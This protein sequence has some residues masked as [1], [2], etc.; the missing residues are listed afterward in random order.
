VARRLAAI[1]PPDISAAVEAEVRNRMAQIV[2]SD[3]TAAIEAA[4]AQRIA[5]IPPPDNSAAIEAEVQRRLSAV[6]AG[7]NIAATIEAEVQRRMALIP[8][9]DNT[10]AIEAEVNRRIAEI[11]ASQPVQTESAVAAPA[12][13]TDEEVEAIV[14]ERLAAEQKKVDARLAKARTDF[15][16][17]KA[18]AVKTALDAK[19]AE[20]N[21]QVATT[22]EE[23][24]KQIAQLQAT[25]EELKKQIA[26]LKQ[27]YEQVKSELETA[28]ATATTVS[29]SSTNE[30]ELRKALEAKELEHQQAIE[31]LKQ[32]EQAK[33]EEAK[34]EVTH[35]LQADF[36]ARNTEPD[37]TRKPPPTK[38]ELTAIIKKNVEHRLVKERAK[39]EAQVEAERE[40][41]VEER[42]S[43]VVE[44]RV[45]N[46]V[47]ER[48]N[49]AI[50]EKMKVK[51][52]ELQA[53]LEKS[54]DALR[55]E[56]QARIKVQLN[57]LEKKNKV[58]EEKLKAATDGS[59]APA[60]SG[61]PTPGQQ[62][63]LPQ[64]GLKPPGMS[65][66][67]HPNQQQLQQQQ[68]QQQQLQQQQ[69]QQ[70]QQGQQGQ[71]MSQI[72]IPPTQRR[73]AVGTGPAALRSLRGALSSNIP[74]GGAGRG[75]A[76][77]GRGG[78]QAG[79]P[80]QTHAIPPQQFPQM[81]QPQMGQQQMGQQQMGQQQ[82][83]VPP[84]QQPQ[85]GQ[86]M[87]L[88]T[89]Q[90]Q[91]QLPRGGGMM[92]R[93]GIFRPQGRGAGGQGQNQGA[94]LQM[95]QQQQV[96]NIQ[97]GLPMTGQQGSQQSPG[98]IMNPGA[99]Q[100]VPIKRSRDDGTEEDPAAG[101][102]VRGGHNG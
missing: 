15:A 101:K 79:S 5:Q 82:M 45:K 53:T 31:K 94:G 14:R 67:P 1:P 61:I 37:A 92:G 28:K 50:E 43:S 18:T 77:G 84:G 69:H 23:H 41:L 60:P 75:I 74:R 72:P 30:E 100:F 42:V 26:T 90:P 2:P 16:A 19:I 91:T 87:S 29:T 86:R 9:P 40:K 76:Q 34:T 13:K 52:S 8:P 32:E 10:A 7:D 59:G 102:R 46:A 33:I 89:G 20:F 88:P 64:S 68:L 55:Q 83:G 22:E 39:W 17:Y 36:L 81:G 44:E 49:S 24:K 71:D 66:I 3:N 35:Q 11:Q 85:F 6:P 63:P 27:Q 21:E 54:K 38:E 98:R 51:E 97:T 78:S 96:P 58:L 25:I 47:E 12:G 99:R 48:V 93:G 65:A 95:Q 62:M 73:D 57:M 4:V 70:H 80:T 56:G